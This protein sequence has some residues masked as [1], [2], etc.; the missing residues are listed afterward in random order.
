MAI[1]Y[2]NSLVFHHGYGNFSYSAK[3]PAVTVDTIYDLASLT[4]VVST[5]TLVMQLFEQ[6]QLKLDDPLIRFYPSF[7]GG[8]REKITL[9]HLLTHTS[10]LPAHRP[11]YRQ[12]NGKEEM[13]KKILNLP[14]KFKPGRN[15]EYSDLGIILLGDI[16]EKLTGKTLDTL[17]FEQIFRPLGMSR[18]QFNP[19]AEPKI[20]NRA[21]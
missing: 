21:H 11:L 10:G 17:S 15:A 13:V 12:V 19:S 5:T 14:L 1:G 7:K 4:K 8:G 20:Q 9:F 3:S 16:I 2:R 18:T 6:G